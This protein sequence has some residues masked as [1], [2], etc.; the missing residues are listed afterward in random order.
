MDIR[1]LCEAKGLTI[2]KLARMVGKSENLLYKIAKGSRK[3]TPE[4]EQELDKIASSGTLQQSTGLCTHVD[5]YGTTPPAQPPTQPPEL[6]VCPSCGRTPAYYQPREVIEYG[7]RLSSIQELLTILRQECNSAMIRQEV[8]EAFREERCGLATFY[9]NELNTVV[10]PLQCVMTILEEDS[11]ANKYVK[12]LIK[13]TIAH[14]GRAAERLAA[15]SGKCK[16]KGVRH[17]MS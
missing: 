7:E 15:E 3:M 14:I 13:Q 12:A 10:V 6:G 9:L 17:D 4:L 11:D 2:S 1:Q 16:P 5:K 8:R